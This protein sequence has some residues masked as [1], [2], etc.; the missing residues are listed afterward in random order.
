MQFLISLWELYN[1]FSPWPKVEQSTAKILRLLLFDVPACSLEES[2]VLSLCSPKL[3]SCFWLICSAIFKD[4]RLLNT[5]NID[6]CTHRLAIQL[7]APRD[8][9]KHE[10]DREWNDWC[11]RWLCCIS[12]GC[13]VFCGYTLN[14][15][16]LCQLTAIEISDFY[17]GK[18][19]VSYIGKQLYTT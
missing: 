15:L 2:L 12:V 19:S 7:N 17:N 5:V 11:E 13:L 16:L 10:W 1:T 6:I 4:L 3:P 14:C 9:G 18:K 8:T